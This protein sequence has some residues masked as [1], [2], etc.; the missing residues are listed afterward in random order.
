MSTKCNYLLWRCDEL[1]D[2][3]IHSRGTT[4]NT[5]RDGQHGAMCIHHDA[6]GEGV[7]SNEKSEIVVIQNWEA[8]AQRNRHNVN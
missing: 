4:G 6:L 1:R 3:N 5:G 2:F 8:E 7:T